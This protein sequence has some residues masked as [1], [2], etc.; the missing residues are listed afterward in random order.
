MAW[1]IECTIIII[2]IIILKWLVCSI[3]HNINIQQD[4][5]LHLTC[6]LITLDITI[7]QYPQQQH[8]F[9]H[10][11]HAHLYKLPCQIY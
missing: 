7:Q 8:I 1:R 11:Y 10:T 2:I 5:L 6:N 9:F 3:T 4:T